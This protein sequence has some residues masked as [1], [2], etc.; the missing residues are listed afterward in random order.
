MK[1]SKFLKP[2]A[3]YFKEEGVILHPKDFPYGV[4][5]DIEIGKVH[6]RIENISRKDTN[7][8]LRVSMI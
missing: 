8:I 7:P 4:V 5:E 1:K 6:L 3:I 2:A